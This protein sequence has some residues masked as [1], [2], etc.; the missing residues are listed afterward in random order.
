MRKLGRLVNPR[1]R[2]VS[3]ENGPG[4]LPEVTHRTPEDR[5]LASPRS[6]PEQSHIFT[7]PDGVR[8]E[9]LRVRGRVRPE[10]SGGAPAAGEDS[11]GERED[12][13]PGVFAR[14]SSRLRCLRVL[15]AC[16]GR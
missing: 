13:E 5:V 9:H 6:R 7:L 10:D 2:G 12:D 3:L 1:L 15:D 16:V 4:S 8:V 11:R 14:L